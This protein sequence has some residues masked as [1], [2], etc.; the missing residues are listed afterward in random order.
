MLILKLC[1][2]NKSEYSFHSI[3]C[4][5]LLEAKPVDLLPSGESDQN[6]VLETTVAVATNDGSQQLLQLLS[7][8]QQTLM[9]LKNEQQQNFEALKNQILISRATI[10]EEQKAGFAEMKNEYRILTRVTVI[11][12]AGLHTVFSPSMF[13]LLLDFF[14]T[15]F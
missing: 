5:H 1:I 6:G 12:I 2:L 15:V 10:I 3:L 4:S 7:S 9:E 14:L 11:I 13:V 8:Q